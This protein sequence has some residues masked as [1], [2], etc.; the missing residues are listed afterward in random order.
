M[1]IEKIK[2]KI[3]EKHLDFTIKNSKSP[4]YLILDYD[5]YCILLKELRVNAVIECDKYD[6]MTTAV[7]YH[8]S[9]EIVEVR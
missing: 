2:D 1:N 6:G 4:E 8:T 9:L 3:N 5:T 7:V